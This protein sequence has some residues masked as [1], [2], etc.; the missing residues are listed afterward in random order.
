MLLFLSQQST[1][2]DAVGIFALEDDCGEQLSDS[3]K[4]TLKM[5]EAAM[6]A[7]L[8]QWLRNATRIVCTQIAVVL[9][10]VLPIAC[11]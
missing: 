11:C 6:H 7:K 10:Q 1:A 2:Y 4:G 3:L 8:P 9:E 5:D